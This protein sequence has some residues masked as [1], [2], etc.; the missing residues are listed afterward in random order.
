M[1]TGLGHWPLVQWVQCC[2][3]EP[4]SACHRYWPRSHCHLVSQLLYFLL[5]PAFS[6]QICPSCEQVIL[7]MLGLSCFAW[8]NVHDLVC[9]QSLSPVT[10]FSTLP[11]EVKGKFA[12]RLVPV[13]LSLWVWCCSDSRFTVVPF[14]IQIDSQSAE[15]ST[16]DKLSHS[17]FFQ[18]PYFASSEIWDF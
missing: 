13:K 4:R 9:H 14:C 8:F 10:D 15:L 18:F 5:H 12:R 2:P 3:L 11:F 16:I 7:S 17:F 6:L 1:C